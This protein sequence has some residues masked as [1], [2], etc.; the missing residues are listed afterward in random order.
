MPKQSLSP[1]LGKTVVFPND[2]D[3]DT[4]MSPLD[5]LAI[6]N[7]LNSPQYHTLQNSRLVP[8]TNNALPFFDVDGDGLVSPLDVLI[9]INAINRGNSG[10]EGEAVPSPIQDDLFA[11]SVWLDQWLDR[12]TEL[13]AHHR[14][15]GVR[16]RLASRQK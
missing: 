7:E 3:N 10:G 2:V 4:F 1:H 5:V 11:D 13:D 16:H 6:V 14:R 8:R 12:S 15:S 9:V